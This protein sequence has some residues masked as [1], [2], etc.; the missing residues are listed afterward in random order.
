[1]LEHVGRA[2]GQ[3]KISG[4]R[5]ELL[6]ITLALTQCASVG[7]AAAIVREDVPGDRRIVGYV[8]PESGQ[9]PQPKTVRRELEERLPDY[10]VP[11]SVVVPDTLPLTLNGKID[12]TRLPAPENSLS[13]RTRSSPPTPAA[14]YRSGR[15]QRDRD[16]VDRPVVTLQPLRRAGS[17]ALGAERLRFSSHSRGG[18]CHW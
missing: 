8:V 17:S 9:A 13:L 4:F 15:A 1:M 12:Q 5:I 2:D 14:R 16:R 10:M 3:V 11:S 7:R 6:E 18:R